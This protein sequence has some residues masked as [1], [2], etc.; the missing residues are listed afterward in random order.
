MSLNN[1]MDLI[2]NE[3]VVHILSY[4]REKHLI[5]HTTDIEIYKFVKLGMVCRRWRDIIRSY[6]WDFIIEPMNLRH[7]IHFLTY[8]NFHKYKFFS[9]SLDSKIRNCNLDRLFSMMSHCTYMH[10]SGLGHQ[11]LDEHLQHLVNVKY[12]NLENCYLITGKYLETLPKL[13]S[14]SLNFNEQFD[15]NVFSKLSQL[16]ELNLS[17]LTKLTDEIFDGLPNLKKLDIG[18]CENIT[19]RGIMKLKSLETIE[20]LLC[21]GITSDIIDCLQKF[22]SIKHVRYNDGKIILTN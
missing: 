6:R 11:V 22:P 14:L 13:K 16:E 12:L 19:N 3:I 17:T 20:I 4:A 8:Y 2:S 18:C 9:V 10:L 5:L 21:K 1:V 15:P 7:L